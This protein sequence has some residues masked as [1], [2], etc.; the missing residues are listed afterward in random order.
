MIELIIFYIGATIMV[1]PFALFG[2]TNYESISIIVCLILCPIISLL[3]LFYSTVKAKN[4]YI[5]YINSIL[6]LLGIVFTVIVFKHYNIIEYCDNLLNGN[7]NR[8][9][10]LYIFKLCVKDLEGLSRLLSVN[11]FIT[12][13][14]IYMILFPII[15][16]YP[17]ISNKILKLFKVKG[18]I[19]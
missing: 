3:S 10:E 16:L 5:K 11:Y 8:E 15:V 4:K 17:I 1:A 9:L 19:H 14:L 18:Y 7:T 6:V 2:Y 12:N 13:I